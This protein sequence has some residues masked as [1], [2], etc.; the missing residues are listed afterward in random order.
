MLTSCASV[1]HYCVTVIPHTT[2]SYFDIIFAHDTPSSS[3]SPLLCCMFSFSL[4]LVVGVSFRLSNE[5]L[6]SQFMTGSHCFTD[7]E[8]EEVCI[9]NGFMELQR[10]N[11]YNKS[12]MNPFFISLWHSNLREMSQCQV[13]NMQSHAAPTRA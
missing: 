10:L 3:Y 5:S 12:T 11:K 7:T 9:T 1:C 13:K 2:T 4:I 6:L 8:I